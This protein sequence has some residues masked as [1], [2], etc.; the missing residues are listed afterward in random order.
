MMRKWSANLIIAFSIFHL[1][2]TYVL[3]PEAVVR[4]ISAGFLG[5]REWAFD[6]PEALAA[7]WFSAFSWPAL[8]LGINLLGTYRQIGDIPGARMT[9]AVLAMSVILCGL[10]LPISGLW[11]FLVP[12]F[13][14]MF[15][16]PPR[17]EIAAA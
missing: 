9:G 11:A 12:A 2:M 5:G 7:F 10:V 8:A 15:G 6:D 16:K 13:M 3:F 1:A 4:I 17:D 14:L